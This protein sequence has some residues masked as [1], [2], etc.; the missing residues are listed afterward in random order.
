MQNF[1]VVALVVA[2]SSGVAIGVQ[3]TLTNWGGRLVGAVNT[4]LL[5][6]AVGGAIALVMLLTFGARLTGLTWGGF[7]SVAIMVTGAGLLG[8]GIITGIAFSLPR[9]GIAAG[10]TAIL[11]GQMLIATIVDTFGWGGLEPI[12]FSLSRILGLAALALA[13]WLLL[14][15]TAS[16]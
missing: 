16:G 15:S 3:A 2:V 7:R 4:G 13:T 6:N 14:P 1:V 5:T 11:L 8:I 9:T 10:L 12:P